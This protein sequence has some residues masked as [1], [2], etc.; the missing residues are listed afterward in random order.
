MYKLNLGQRKMRFKFNTSIWTIWRLIVAQKEIQVLCLLNVW[1]YICSCNFLRECIMHSAINISLEACTFYLN[2]ALCYAY[3]NFCKLQSSIREILILLQIKK[4]HLFLCMTNM[5]QVPLTV[6]WNEMVVHPP[7]SPIPN[8]E[9]KGHLS[10]S[11]YKKGA[12]QWVCKSSYRGQH[13][14]SNCIDSWK[15]GIC[16]E[17]CGLEESLTDEWKKP[18]A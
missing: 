9:S 1:W 14:L 2:T 10:G 7:V 15:L 17:T 8:H 11:W 18:T 6:Q 4:D 13:W 5:D 12:K 3:K 16:L